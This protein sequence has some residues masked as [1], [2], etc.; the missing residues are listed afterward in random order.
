MTY[1]NMRNKIPVLALLGMLF[2][3]P[4]NAQEQFENPDAG[5]DR[6]AVAYMLAIGAT[7]L[8]LSL[9]YFLAGSDDTPY[10]GVPLLVAG[11]MIGP[12]VGQFYAGSHLHGWG[13]AALRTI[14]GL[15]FMAGALE[16]Y[17]DI[18]CTDDCDGNEGGPAM[19]AGL[20]VGGA[21]VLY[22]LV[23]THFAFSRPRSEPEG[24]R[25]GWT[26]ALGVT[27]EGRTAYGARAW[28]QF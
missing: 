20:I 9:G 10:M 18:L 8:P 17:D 3:K 16:A 7:V 13:G 4:G 1:A 21:G 23:D 25:L 28:Y 26:P 19:A 11:G 27:R 5:G 24:G 12:S 14:G 6:E 2:L 22:S 15:I